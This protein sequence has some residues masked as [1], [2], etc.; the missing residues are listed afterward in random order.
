MQDALAS[1]VDRI[2]GPEGPTSGV[3]MFCFWINYHVWKR[4]RGNI[5]FPHVGRGF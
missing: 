1:C 5:D 3:H 4:V 2:E